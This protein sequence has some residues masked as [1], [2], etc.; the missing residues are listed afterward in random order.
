MS[1]EKLKKIMELESLM[2]SAD[3]WNDKIKAQAVLKEISDL[4]SEVAGKDK[5]NKGDA[6]MTI[7]S[8]AGGD[9][10]EDF[11]RILF[12]MYCKFFDKQDRKSVV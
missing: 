2:L 1:E 4:K 11:S 7:F 9:D 6:I 3:F 5:Y 12:E 8:G 10:A